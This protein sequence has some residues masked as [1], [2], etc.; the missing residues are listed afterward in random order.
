MK[1][2]QSIFFFV[3]LAAV[4]FSEAL[5]YFWFAQVSD[6]GAML[7]LERPAASPDTIDF[8]MSD[9]GA[10]EVLSF[11]RSQSFRQLFIDDD[12]AKQ[13]M[14]IALE[15]DA[16]NGRVWRDIFGHSPDICMPTSGAIP[17]GEAVAPSFEVSFSDCRIMRYEFTH[18]SEAGPVFVYKLVWLGSEGWLEGPIPDFDSWGMRVDFIVNRKSIPAASLMLAMVRG[19]EE[20][21]EAD[22]VFESFV[23]ANC[24]LK[25]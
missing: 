24:F 21:E 11:H 6:D 14:V 9:S 3:V 16:G 5:P 17:V 7:R 22:G 19:Y 2:P 13:L 18:P 4:A 10:G 23:L 25:E 15:Y 1:R 8:P 12:P 20:G